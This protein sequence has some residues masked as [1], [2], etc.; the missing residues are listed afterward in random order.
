[1][2]DTATLT[3][4]LNVFR[5]DT[6]L[7]QKT[8]KLLAADLRKAAARCDELAA[9]PADQPPTPDAPTPGPPAKRQKGRFDFTRFAQRYVV[10]RLFYVGWRYH[11]FA[12]QEHEGNTVEGHLFRAL[13]RTCLLPPHSVWSDVGYTRCGRTDVGVS[14]LHQVLTI[15]LR[16]KAPAGRAPPSPA[17]ELDYPFILNKVLPDDIQVTG[18]R[19]AE[20]EF[21]ARFSCRW[22]EYNYFIAGAPRVC[23]RARGWCC[24]VHR[25]LPAT[26]VRTTT[27]DAGAAAAQAWG[28]WTWRRCRRRRPTLRASTTSRTFAR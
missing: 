3:R 25:V 27:A 10:L 14:A 8:A 18:W 23:A 16:S 17:Q 6:N 24:L 7:T 12:S 13:E 22:R 26:R 21:H 5:P 11:G 9:A 4:L 20:A 19:P 15:R 28:S 1:M 2:I